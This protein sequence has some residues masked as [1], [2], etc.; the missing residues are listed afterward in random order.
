MQS[1]QLGTDEAGELLVP[2]LQV[3][4]LHVAYGTRSILRDVSLQVQSGH[5]HAIIGPSGCG[6]STLLRAI[7]GIVPLQSG[8]I[9]LF[10]RPLTQLTQAAQQ[11]QLQQI[12]VMFQSGALLGSLSSLENVALP[13]RETTN[14]PD[15]IIEDVAIMKL[16]LVGLG[17][18]AHLMPDALSGGMRKRVALARALVRDPALLICDEPSAGLDPVTAADLDQLLMNLR[19]RCATTLLIVTHELA[20]ITRIA[21]QVTL[22]HEGVVAFDG[23]LQMA[24]HNPYPPLRAFFDR[25]ATPVPA[26]ASLASALLLEGER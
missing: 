19:D 12:G 21:D 5:I 15:S 25:V 6:K 26:E 2:I 17:H 23:S 4:K 11:Q 8:Q 3:A 22:L 10:G 18:A 7:V 20:S 13:L 9:E 14:L 1:D 24:Q 16:H